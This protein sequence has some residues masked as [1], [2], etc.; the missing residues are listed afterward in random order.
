GR[1]V[2]Q[3]F[4]KQFRDAADGTRAC[5]QSVV[6]APVRVRRVRARPSARE[7]A[8]RIHP[9]DSHPIDQELGLADQRALLAFDVEIDFD[10]EDGIEVGR[11]AAR[12]DGAPTS[13]TPVPVADGS[14]I[15]AAARYVWRELNAITR[16]SLGRL[17]GL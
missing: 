15:E 3:V 8:V 5:Y 2:G 6:E 10:V 14:P 4:L 16:A 1:R 9:L 11:V 12:P 13:V 17:R 7:W